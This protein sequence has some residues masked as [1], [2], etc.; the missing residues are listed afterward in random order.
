MMCVYFLNDTYKR[1]IYSQ[2]NN[3]SKM[4]QYEPQ[5]AVFKLSLKRIIHRKIIDDLYY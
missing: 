3:F 2:K 1:I 4:T 5:H